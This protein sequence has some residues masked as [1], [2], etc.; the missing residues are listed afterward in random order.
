[1]FALT[2]NGAK[3]SLMLKAELVSLMFLA[4]ECRT[5]WKCVSFRSSFLCPFDT[6]D[7][8]GTSGLNKIDRLITVD[9]SFLLMLGF[10]PFVNTYKALPFWKESNALIKRKKGM[11]NLGHNCGISCCR[12]S[13][14]FLFRNFVLGG[15]QIL[16]LIF[17]L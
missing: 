2:L 8:H 10:K 11:R 3:A 12:I 16:P 1:M 13:D 4:R 15:E 17:L 9:N 14:I 7:N 5:N 6:L